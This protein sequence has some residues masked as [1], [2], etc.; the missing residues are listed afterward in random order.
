MLTRVEAIV[1]RCR[2]VLLGGGEDK[3]CSARVVRPTH[4]NLLWLV[5]PSRFL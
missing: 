5:A 3:Y 2:C 1:G 4:D